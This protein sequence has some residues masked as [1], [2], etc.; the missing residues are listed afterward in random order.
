MSGQSEQCTHLLTH[1]I[2]PWESI[3]ANNFPPFPT[4]KK[5]YYTK[6]ITASLSRIL[7]RKKKD[8]N[9]LNVQYG[10]FQNYNQK[11][12]VATW[13]VLYEV[14]LIWKHRLP[15]GKDILTRR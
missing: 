5:L 15:D 12:Y 1:F 4:G 3:P 6:L 13:N 2:S 7:K 14:L 11:D 10:N 8:G 9:N